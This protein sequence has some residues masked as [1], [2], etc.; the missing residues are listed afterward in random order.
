MVGDFNGYRFCSLVTKTSS[1]LTAPLQKVFFLYASIF[2]YSTLIAAG[3]FNWKNKIKVHYN[4][5]KNLNFI[6]Y[7]YNWNVTANSRMLQ[8]LS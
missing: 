8:T 3:N 4:I 7:L 5:S 1:S 2:T 6:I